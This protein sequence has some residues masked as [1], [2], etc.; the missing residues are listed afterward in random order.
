MRNFFNKIREKLLKN[1]KNIQFLNELKIINGQILSNQNKIL[2]KE[3]HESEFKIFSQFGE[4]GII[5]FILNTIKISKK[6]FIEFG[7]ENYE[8]ANTRFLLEC[9]NWNGLIIDNSAENINFI[10]KQNYFWKYDLKVEK[11]FINKENINQIFLNNNMQGDIG[12]LSI[13]IDG[14]DY[15]VWKE[16][17]VVNPDLVIIEYNARCCISIQVFLS[18]QVSKTLAISG[19]K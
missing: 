10:K 14:N 4:D 3:I 7:V 12:I 16:I 11:K 8:E 19:S 1:E 6:T 15:W 5:Q 9:N 13:D 18:P 2:S 17:N